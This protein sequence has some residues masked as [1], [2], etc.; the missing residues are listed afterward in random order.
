MSERYSI[1]GKVE[2]VARTRKSFKVGDDWF[3]VFKG[4]QLGEAQAGDEV[5]FEYTVVNK[6]GK[7]F[8]NVQGDVLVT[9]EG[10]RQERRPASRERPSGS[11]NRQAPVRQSSERGSGAE[12]LDVQRSIVRQNS[13]TQANALFSSLV[14]LGVMGELGYEEA[15]ATVLE[16]A[17]DFEKYSMVED[18]GE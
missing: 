5:E 18:G 1:S 13:L 2:A 14:R 17:R 11:R 10:A 7:E 4:D 16:L 12:G 9:A 6:G 8:L 15:V 3:S